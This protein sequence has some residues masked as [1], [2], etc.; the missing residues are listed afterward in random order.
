MG[1]ASSLAKLP[2]LKFVLGQLGSL[3]QAWANV[4]AKIGNLRRNKVV[5]QVAKIPNSR[6]QQAAVHP[7][8]VSIALVLLV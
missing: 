4:L 6:H 7:E 1:R 8:A 2:L 5:S 3:A